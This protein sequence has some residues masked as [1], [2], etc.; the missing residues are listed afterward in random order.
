MSE[1]GGIR[2]DECE[3]DG[4]NSNQGNQDGNC[5]EWFNRDEGEPT[6]D[7]SDDEKCEEKFTDIKSKVIVLQEL[8]C[9]VG[10]RC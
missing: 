5:E 9:G 6:S 7:S 1:N 3:A 10:K 8:E 4:R 2:G